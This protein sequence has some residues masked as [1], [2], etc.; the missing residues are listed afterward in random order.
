MCLNQKKDLLH[1]ENYWN[2]L[3]YDRY[4]RMIA[5]DKS[6]GKQLQAL[7]SIFVL[8]RVVLYDIYIWFF[9]V[10]CQYCKPQNSKAI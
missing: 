1:F 7:L 8:C 3:G 9:I 6:I 4:I 5:A 10:K 2:T